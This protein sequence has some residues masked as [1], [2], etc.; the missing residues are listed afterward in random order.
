M[1]ITSAAIVA[2]ALKD[3]NE[4]TQAMEQPNTIKESVAAKPIQWLIV[5]GVVLYFA[6]K[7]LKNVGDGTGG[8]ETASNENPF[9]FNNF[10]EWNKVPAGTK[11][12]EYNDAVSKARAIYNALDVFVYENE[13]IVVGVFTSLPSKIQVAQVAKVFFDWY[14][15]DI[16]TYISQGNKTLSFGTGG[17]SEH[18]YNR[19][20]QNVSK[21]P[22]F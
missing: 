8:A 16:L 10:L 21:K 12:L 20:L 19:I 18:N 1:S 13:D 15:K 11:I 5:A 17:L 22:K 3:K 7:F 2:A 4:N 9:A 14:G 6:N